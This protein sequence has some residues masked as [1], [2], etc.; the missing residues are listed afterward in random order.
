MSSAAVPGATPWQRLRLPLIAFIGAAFYSEP[1][2]LATFLGAAV[3]FSG[4]YYRLARETRK[5]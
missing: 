4:S 5:P 3:I 1:L 2:E